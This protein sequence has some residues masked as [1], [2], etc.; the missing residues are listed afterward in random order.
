MFSLRKRTPGESFLTRKYSQLMTKETS[1][2][3]KLTQNDEGEVEESS[4]DSEDTETRNFCNVH[5][6][7]ILSTDRR[8]NTINQAPIEDY[9][10]FWC[11]T[12]FF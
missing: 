8:G 7:N 10:S 4:S 3:Y 12:T 6:D 5:E 9:R 1:V 2:E 11:S